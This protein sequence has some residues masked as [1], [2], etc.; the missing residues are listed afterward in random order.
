MSKSQIGLW[1]EVE[2]FVQRGR[3]AQEAVDD[4]LA[5]VRARKTDPESSHQAA[6]D[7]VAVRHGSP[8]ASSELGR[9]QSLTLDLVRRG[10]GQ[11]SHELADGN[12]VLRYQIARRLPELARR[13]MV[14]RGEARA[15]RVTGRLATT[16]SVYQD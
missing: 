16:W 13:G 1:D 14:K 15:C 3:A 5:R 2:G 8:Q 6:R 11:T 9:Q 4:I 7:L 12:T 10:P